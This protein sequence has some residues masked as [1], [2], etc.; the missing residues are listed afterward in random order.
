MVSICFSRNCCSLHID[1]LI[2]GGVI[3]E[4]LEPKDTIG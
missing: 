3:E 4:L 2:V 1:E